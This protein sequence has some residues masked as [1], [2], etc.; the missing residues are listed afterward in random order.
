MDVTT[1]QRVAFW[2]VPIAWLGTK[3]KGDSGEPALGIRYGVGG[4]GVSIANRLATVDLGPWILRKGMTL[5]GEM[6]DGWYR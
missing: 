1:C 4:A 6:R 3:P 5:T 2:S